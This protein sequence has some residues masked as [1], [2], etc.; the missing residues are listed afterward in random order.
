M[1]KFVAF[2]SALIV[3]SASPAIAQKRPDRIHL[4]ATSRSGAVLIRVPV[5]PFDYTLQF[6]RNGNSGFLSRVYQMNVR[7]GPPGYRYIARTLSPGRYR[8]D[9]VWQQGR[10]SACLERATIEIPVEAGRIAYVGTLQVD[11]ILAAIQQSAIE[12]GRT[13]VAAGD[14]VVSRP[15]DVR[16][17]I[18]GR[19]EAGIA[20]ARTFAQ[21][22]M[23]GSGNLLQLAQLNETSFSTSGASR[24]IE[25]CG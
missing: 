3:V 9:S 24:L 19:D 22:V 8:L 10:W 2:A 14:F 16:P 11:S 15:D 23:N 18:D 17:I 12:R 5:Q 21:T 25:I 7:A 13:S 20:D 6:S 4:T 1:K